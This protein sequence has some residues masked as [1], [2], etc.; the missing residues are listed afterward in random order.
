MEG[1]KHPAR[2]TALGGADW[3]S[4]EGY[5]PLCLSD[6]VV[7]GAELRCAGYPSGFTRGDLAGGDVFDHILFLHDIGRAGRIGR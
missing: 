3:T 1:L 5:D 4:A 7:W 6:H 2:F